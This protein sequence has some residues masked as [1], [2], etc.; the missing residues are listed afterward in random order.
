M[1]P[2]S[3]SQTSCRRKRP[4][5]WKSINTHTH[6][7]A[8]THTH[9]H[10]HTHTRHH[11][12][13]IK[14]IWILTL[15]Q[16]VCNSFSISRHEQFSQTWILWWILQ[17]KNTYTNTIVFNPLRLQ[18]NWN[19]VTLNSRGEVRKILFPGGLSYQKGLYCFNLK[20]SFIHSNLKCKKI[21]PSHTR[22][23]VFHILRFSYFTFKIFS[24][25]VSANRNKHTFNKHTTSN[26]K[27]GKP[28]KLGGRHL[29]KLKCHL[30]SIVY[31]STY[32]L[33]LMSAFQ[34]WQRFH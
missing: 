30:F 29:I 28:C 23:L 24:F 13:V 10:T 2:S 31:W 21:S 7:H 25:L 6:T 15:S 17:W 12:H 1:C 9:T 26:P 33:A 20:Y 22:I 32:F 5:R 18:G 14:R 11:Q 16:R 27:S 8:R 4:S 34:K 19:L 3:M